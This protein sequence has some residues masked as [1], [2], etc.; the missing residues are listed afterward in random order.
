MGMKARLY[1]AFVCS[2]WIEQSQHEASSVCHSIQHA[3]I[4][5]VVEIQNHHVLWKVM[6]SRYVFCSKLHHIITISRGRTELNCLGT[7][8]H[9]WKETVPFCLC[10]FHTNSE[11]DIPALKWQCEMAYRC[12]SVFVLMQQ[13]NIFGHFIFLFSGQVWDENINIYLMTE[14]LKLLRYRFLQRQWRP[15]WVL[16]TPRGLWC[17]SRIYLER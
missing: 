9:R 4:I 8:D 13:F 14:W 10:S 12:L 15:N 3:S 11:V 1:A 2:H 7:M 6:Y 5:M 16:E 17:P